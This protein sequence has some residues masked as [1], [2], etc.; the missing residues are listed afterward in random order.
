MDAVLR[1]STTAML[2]V[3][4]RQETRAKADGERRHRR[5]SG[6]VVGR[7][8]YNYSPISILLQFYK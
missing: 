2:T 3:V 1:V 7:V 6:R 4:E 8:R 5:Y